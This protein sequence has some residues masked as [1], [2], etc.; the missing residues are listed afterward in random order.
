MMM[1]GEVQKWFAQIDDYP[2]KSESNVEGITKVRNCSP[3]SC[4]TIAAAHSPFPPPVAVVVVAV[5]RCWGW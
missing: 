3:S 5:C 1:K 2:S 4:H